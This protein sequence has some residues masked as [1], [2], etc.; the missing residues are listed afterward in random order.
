[1]EHCA[2]LHDGIGQH[3]TASGGDLLFVV[4]CLTALVAVVAIEAR[5]FRIAAQG[6][7]IH[8]TAGIIL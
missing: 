4:N 8:G 3:V 5:G 2:I 1:M 6:L 7:C